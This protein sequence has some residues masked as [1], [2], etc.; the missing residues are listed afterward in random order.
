[1]VLLRDIDHWFMERV[2]PFAGTYLAYARRLTRN[3]EEAE[4]LVQE[5]YARVI[6]YAKWQQLDAPNRFTLR[7]IHN[8]AVERIRQSK[9]ITIIQVGS[10]EME[11]WPDW[12]PDPYA[13]AES[14]G[15]LRRVSA[16]LS[17]L[18]EKCR[19]VTVLRKIFGLTP[20][21]IA[22]RLAISVST[23]EKH[24]AKG[25]RLLTQALAE[26]DNRTVEDSFQTWRQSSIAG[27]PE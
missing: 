3:R 8:L 10:L 24:L 22:E 17:R 6:G 14:R 21:Q 1:M 7:I 5:A 4:D 12:A 9:V 18:P 27:K 20:L 25:L 11:A 26:E 2:L 16:A 19:E 15:E 23:V 13:V